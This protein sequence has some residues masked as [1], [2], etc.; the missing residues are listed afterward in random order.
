MIFTQSLLSSS[1]SL[2]NQ[3]A[4]IVSNRSARSCTVNVLRQEGHAQKTATATIATTVKNTKTKEKRK[5]KKK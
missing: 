5:T 1:K 4:V 3:K 2:Q